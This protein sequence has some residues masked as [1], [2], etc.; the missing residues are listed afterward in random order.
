MIPI[1]QTCLINCYFSVNIDI[2]SI[3]TNVAKL[4]T[5]GVVLV[6]VLVLIQ[7]LLLLLCFGSPERFLLYVGCLGSVLVIV[8]AWFLKCCVVPTRE[9]APGN[10]LPTLALLGGVSMVLEPTMENISKGKI[11]NIFGTTSNTLLPT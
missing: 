4:C 6:L 8:L 3:V 10:I 9:A 5:P 1:V 7:L 11:L 2:S